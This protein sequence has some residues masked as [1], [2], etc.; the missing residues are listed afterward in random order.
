MKPRQPSES[1][2]AKSHKGAHLLRPI[3]KEQ[4]SPLKWVEDPWQIRKIIVIH[5]AVLC[6]R[7]SVSFF[8]GRIALSTRER[9]ATHAQALH[10]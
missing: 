7:Q 6:A 9:S 3:S 10:F 4:F 2:G 8:P 1:V 5:P